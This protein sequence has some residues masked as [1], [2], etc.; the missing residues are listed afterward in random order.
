MIR[1]PVPKSVNM[2]E[3]AGWCRKQFGPF[4]YLGAVE[5]GIVGQADAEGIDVDII[6]A[7]FVIRWDYNM[8]TFYF[9]DHADAVL[10]RLRW[11]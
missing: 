10:F 11:L 6:D 3:A 4:E 1:I 8:R 2:F 9:R 7:N 5:F